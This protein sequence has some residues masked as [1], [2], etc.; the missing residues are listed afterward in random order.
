MRLTKAALVYCRTRKLPSALKELAV[1]RHELMRYPTTAI[2]WDIEDRSK[3]PPWGNRIAPTITS[4][5]NYF[6]SSTGQDFFD[7]LNETLQ[8]ALKHKRP[9]DIV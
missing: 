4:V 2:I 1:I 7:L 5:G 8:H 3:A 6:V 9:V